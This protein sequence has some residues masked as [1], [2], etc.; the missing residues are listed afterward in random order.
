MGCILG[1]MPP[2][3]QGKGASHVVPR[4]ADSAAH[5]ACPRTS[6]EPAAACNWST[7]WIRL[8][9]ICHAIRRAGRKGA[10][11][12]H[13]DA[14]SLHQILHPEFQTLKPLNPKCRSAQCK[15]CGS[16][17]RRAMNCLP[18]ALNSKP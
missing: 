14:T 2:H 12:V 6:S 17:V 9:S 4:S 7:P 3:E 18:Q 11:C 8:Y 5:I 15:R 16:L 10:T 13:L 1:G